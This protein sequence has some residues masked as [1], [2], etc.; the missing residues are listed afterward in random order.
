MKILQI[1]G[2]SKAF[3]GQRALDDVS[4]D[5]DEG[6][7][8]ALVGQNGSGKS[9]LIKVLAGYHEPDPG[10]TIRVKG[11]EYVPWSSGFTKRRDL[12]FVHQDLALVPSLGAIDNIALGRGFETG[13]FGGIRWRAEEHLA[14]TLVHDFGVDFDVHVPI[15]ELSPVQ[16]TVVAMARSVQ[17]VSAEDERSPVSILVL[18]EPTAALPMPQV[19]HLFAAVRQLASRGTAVLYVSHHLDE[20]FE[21][22][23]RI[24]VLRGG[25]V[26]ATMS[27]SE[28]DR[29]GLIEIMLGRPLDESYAGAASR[30]GTPVV[31]DVSHLSGGRLIDLSFQAHSGE[32]VG[33]TGIDGSGREDVASLLYGVGRSRHGTVRVNGSDANQGA[34]AACI[35]TG[36]AFVPADR[37]GRAVLLDHSIRENVT[38]PLL[39][40]LL[41]RWR[42]DRR[43]ERSEVRDWIRRVDLCPADPEQAVSLLSGGNQ[44]KAVL[45]K[46]LR[47]APQVLLL[48]EPMQG[49]DVGAKVAIS[50]LLASAAAAGTALVYVSVEATELVR[51]CTRV[52]VLRNGVVG[53]VLTG[54]SLNVQRLTQECI[55]SPTSAVSESA[56]GAS[57]RARAP[58]L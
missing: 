26:A 51:M 45:A 19:Q 20:V 24:T 29:Q 56:T 48:E 22:A 41:R 11:A 6:E 28:V 37:A 52:I 40:P 16:R 23:D 46:W 58:R 33:I 9:T 13:R 50:G 47:T 44:Q 14:R 34:P 27:C 35:A 49:M 18:D 55:S 15:S 12:G 53:A 32:V 57:S 10:A 54:D 38:L 31:L 39:R 2:L 30:P 4:L 8:H 17:G 3:P 25:R 36:M 1:E 21:L 5:I 42:L 7:V 43:A